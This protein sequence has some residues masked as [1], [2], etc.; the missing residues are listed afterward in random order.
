[1]EG[2]CGGWGKGW[3]GVEAYHIMHGHIQDAPHELDHGVLMP[4]LPGTCTA[5]SRAKVE[6]H[7]VEWWVVG[8]WFQALRPSATPPTFQQ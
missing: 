8:T 4:G 6:G 5:R 3:G 2:E 1:M 7:Q